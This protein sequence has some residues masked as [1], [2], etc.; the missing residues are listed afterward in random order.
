MRKQTTLFITLLLLFGVGTIQHAE[1]CNKTSATLIS[2][3]IS[4]GVYTYV[5]EVCLEFNGLE[6]S[7]DAFTLNFVGAVDIDSFMPAMITT[8]SSD[9]YIGTTTGNGIRYATSSLFPGH[10]TSTLCETYTV[11]TSEAV[12]SIIAQVHEGRGD[13]DCTRVIDITSVSLSPKVFLQG[14]LSGTLMDDDLRVANLIPMAEP[15]GTG[16][17]E[18][19][20]A[21]LLTTTGNDAIVDWVLVELRDPITSTMVLASRAAL[22]QRDGDVVDVDGISPLKIIGISAGMYHVAI[23]HRNHLSI[24]T[25]APVTLN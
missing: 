14:S 23:K 4:S 13:V 8:S 20:S 21:S 16:N 15:Y 19:F 10:N 3:D 17:N 7:P 12:T 6:G 2:C 9:D 22:L 5:F 18:N 25:D 24:M 11:T 1:A